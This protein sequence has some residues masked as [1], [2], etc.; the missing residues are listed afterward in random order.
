M[1]KTAIRRHNERKHFK[2]RLEKWVSSIDIYVDSNGK[3]IYN[4]SV[5]YVE[6][7]GAWKFLKD[8]GKP[9]SCST[10]TPERYDRA[11]EKRGI[12]QELRMAA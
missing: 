4:P 9:C 2:K 5:E 12:L 1:A 7:D 3:Y 6:K 8:T 11:K 10:C